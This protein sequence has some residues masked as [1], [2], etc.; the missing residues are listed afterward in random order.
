M[1]L[2][3]LPIKAGVVVMQM[4]GRVHMG[5]DCAEI[6]HEVEQHILRNEKRL[7]FDLTAVDHIDSAFI[8]QIVKS[9]SRLAKAGGT[10]RLACVSG[11]VENVLKLTQLS[12]VIPIYPS[13]EEAYRDMPGEK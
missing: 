12:K 9:H 13:S 5:K 1:K 8:G 2:V 4:T 3:K 7:V 11:M 6:D 10:L